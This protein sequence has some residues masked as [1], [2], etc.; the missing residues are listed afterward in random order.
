MVGP[1]SDEI[2]YLILCRVVIAVFVTSKEYRGFPTVGKNPAFDSIQSIARRIFSIEAVQV[3]PEFVI[4]YT[5]NNDAS[6]AVSTLESSPLLPVDLSTAGMNANCWM[7]F[8]HLHHPPHRQIATI[9]PTISMLKS[10]KKTIDNNEDLFTNATTGGMLL[11]QIPLDR[12]NN[13]NN[14]NSKLSPKSEKNKSKSNNNNGASGMINVKLLEKRLKNRQR[15]CRR[16][17]LTSW[18]QLAFKCCKAT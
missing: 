1:V 13:N 15:K 2:R 11:A 14:V 4:Q 18:E 17:A 7:Y 9:A 3:L 5:Y 12:E 10:S 8:K 6:K 16:E